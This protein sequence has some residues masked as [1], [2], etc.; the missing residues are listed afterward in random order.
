MNLRN[1]AKFCSEELATLP[2][3]AKEP[4]LHRGVKFESVRDFLHKFRLI[5][6]FKLIVHGLKMVWCQVPGC[7]TGRQGHP[8][9][10]LFRIPTDPQQKMKWIRKI[11]RQGW[12]PK[13]RDSICSRHFEPVSEIR[14]ISPQTKASK[15]PI[16]FQNRY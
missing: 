4:P 16:Y 15:I 12:R 3:L 6:G 5:S 1:F 8:K 10:K 7:K 2:V 11:R 14:T 9:G 13:G